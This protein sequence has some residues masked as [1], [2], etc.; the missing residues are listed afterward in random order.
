[1]ENKQNFL[2]QYADTDAYGVAWHGSYLRFMEAGRVGFLIDRNIQIE[3]LQNE[4][5]IVLP[6]VK[7]DIN[8][9]HPARLMDEVV[10]STKLIGLSKTRAHFLQTISNKKTGKVC[11]VA[12]VV[13]VG[14]Q[15][16]KLMKN[17]DEILKIEPFGEI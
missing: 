13:A 5:N 1:M 10:L 14:V 6:V 16:E 9:K 3:K 8:Y 11:T 17:L 4:Q 12:N 7:I 2:V 15:N